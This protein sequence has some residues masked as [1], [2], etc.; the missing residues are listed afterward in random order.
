MGRIATK[1]YCNTD[2]PSIFNIEE[3]KTTTVR[4]SFTN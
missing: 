2:S 1:S 3:N 4:C